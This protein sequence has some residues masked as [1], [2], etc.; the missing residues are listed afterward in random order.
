MVVVLPVPLTPTMR[1]TLGVALTSMTLRLRVGRPAAISAITSASSSMKGSRASIFLAVQRAS[2]SSTILMV[3]S[4]PDVGGDQ[5]LL[6][7]LVQ[8]PVHAHVDRR[9]EL[10]L[11]GLARLAEVPPEP[12]E[13]AGALALLLFEHRRRHL[14]LAP[15]L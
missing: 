14:L 13:E 12:A 2:S 9:L 11:D 1:I 6:D 3:P 8:A 5:H 15:R 10:V 4:T 7:L